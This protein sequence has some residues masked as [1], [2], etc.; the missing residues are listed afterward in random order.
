MGFLQLLS[1]G[2][3]GTGSEI[4]DRRAVIRDARNRPEPYECPHC[5]AIF[6][7]KQVRI[8]LDPET[9]DMACECPACGKYLYL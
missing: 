8:G 4:Q 3:L 7:G 5:G 2:L 6:E 1:D 9:G